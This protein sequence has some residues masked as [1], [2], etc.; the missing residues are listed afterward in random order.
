MPS[1]YFEGNAMSLIAYMQRTLLGDR[2][3]K[4]DQHG[5]DLIDDM[6]KVFVNPTG[7]FAYAQAG[8]RLLDRLR[9][10]FEAAVL[11]ALLKSYAEGS[12]RLYFDEKYKNFFVHRTTIIAT[13]DRAYR[14]VEDGL[15]NE[16]S[17][18]DYEVSGT[19]EYGFLVALKHYEA[20]PGDIE[21][22]DDTDFRD[23]PLIAAAKM[24]AGYLSGQREARIDSFCTDD[25]KPIVITPPVKE[26]S[27]VE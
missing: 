23:S 18:E 26:N 27:H 1:F 19:I 25:L 6:Q 4:R 17:L 21:S 10:E 20:Y 11:A 15:F 24:S 5:V 14:E 12:H 22:A 9:P 8:Y 7:Q 2:I 3:A 13:A 16:I